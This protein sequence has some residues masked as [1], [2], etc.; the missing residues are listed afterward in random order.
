L[1]DVQQNDPGAPQKPDAHVNGSASKNYASV[2]TGWQVVEGAAT[3]I[4]ESADIILKRGRLCSNGK[5][6]PVDRPDYIKFAQ[7]L[8]TSGEKALAAARAKRQEAVSDITNGLVDA[9]S[10]CHEIYRDKGPSGSLARCTP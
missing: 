8:R 2:Y 9:C 3:A 1:F 5:P 4:A 6:V 10:G 7:Q